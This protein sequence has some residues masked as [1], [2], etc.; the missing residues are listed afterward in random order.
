MGPIRR[1]VFGG[2]ISAGQR[3]VVSHAQ[4]QLA[5][6]IFAVGQAVRLQVEHELQ[7]VLDLAE[8][9]ISVV[10]DAI[11]L[12]GQAADVFQGVQR[13]ERV[14]LADS[15][16]IAAVEELQ[17]LDREFDVADAAVAGLDFLVRVAGPAGLLLDAALERL[18]FVDLGDAEILAI[19]ERLDRLDELLAE[20]QRSPATGR[21]LIRA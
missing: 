11:F 13:L 10:E 5:E 20:A 19:D 9:A 1:A 4:G 17:E 18:D 14:A 6:L 8:E 3:G 15:R 16:Q 2:G 7:A 21:T 12:V